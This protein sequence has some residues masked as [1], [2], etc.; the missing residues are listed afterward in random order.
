MIPLSEA[1]ARTK[2]RGLTVFTRTELVAALQRWKALPSC[3]PFINVEFT[4]DEIAEAIT[5]H[6]LD[7]T[8]LGSHDGKSITAGKAFT[9]LTGRRLTL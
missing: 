7:G 1:R 6:Q 4:D 9:L 5:T 2:A 8:I 3:G